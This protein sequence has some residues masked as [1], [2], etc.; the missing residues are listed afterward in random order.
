MYTSCLYWSPL[1]HASIKPCI[2]FT[3]SKQDN[4]F[5]KIPGRGPRHCWEIPQNGST[6][7]WGWVPENK[8]RKRERELCQL[9]INAF[10]L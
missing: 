4:G 8:Q 6:I 9:N 3:L 10:L 1:L 5:S 2:K 7:V